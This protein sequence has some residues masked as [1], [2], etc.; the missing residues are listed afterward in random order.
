MVHCD[1]TEAW[2]R[3]S[4]KSADIIICGDG[5]TAGGLVHQVGRGEGLIFETR[6]RDHQMYPGRRTK[7]YRAWSETV[8]NL[9]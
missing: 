4:P 3:F 1:T 8:K 6:R 9:R 5:V 2:F 7:Q